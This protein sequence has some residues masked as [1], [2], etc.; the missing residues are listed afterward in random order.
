[1]TKHP[2]K[3]NGRE[4]IKVWNHNKILKASIEVISK[5]GIAGMTITRV[6]ELANVARGLVNKYFQSKDI[7][8]MESLKF[9]AAEYAEYMNKAFQKA[10]SSP[11]EQIKAIV[12]TDFDPKVLNQKNMGIWFAYRSLV[13]SK[14]EYLPY[15][16]TRETDFTNR[17]ISLC[18]VLNTEGNYNLRVKLVVL[19]LEAML[20]GMWLDYNLHPR[21]YNRKEAIETCFLYLGQMFPN[22]YHDFV[23]K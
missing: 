21:N 18:E 5:H 11:I 20:E 1:M 10:G 22:H 4:A 7:L 23:Q 9:M 15:V 16:E 8:L 6:V 14:P 2:P 19:G 12:R 17:L 3:P 13:R